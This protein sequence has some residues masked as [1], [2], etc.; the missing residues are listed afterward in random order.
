VKR[1]TLLWAIVRVGL[2]VALLGVAGGVAAYV[3]STSG[4]HTIHWHFT[5]SISI[6][7]QQATIPEG[8]GIHPNLWRFH[9]L[10]SYAT[11]PGTAPIHT[12]DNTGLIHIEATGP[13]IGYTLGDFFAIW[14]LRFDENCLS[15]IC[16]SNSTVINMFVNGEQ[17]YQFDKYVPHDHD[18]I[19]IQ[20]GPVSQLQSMPGIQYDPITC[21]VFLICA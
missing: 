18:V 14:G 17:N 21:D 11:N 8:V 20:V 6:Y 7:G 10:D 1:K 3:Q 12:H 4:W 13:P 9:A 5:L 16:V 19:S 15:N 2:V